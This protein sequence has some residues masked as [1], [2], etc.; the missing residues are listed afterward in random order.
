MKQI[1]DG[2]NI[3]K[4]IRRLWFPPYD[5]AYVEIN[6]QKYTL[7]NRQLLEEIAPKGS[8]QSFC[9]K[10]KMLNTSL[11]PMAKLYPRRS[12][13]RFQSPA[14]QQSQLLDRYGMSRI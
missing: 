1:L 9:R 6:G 13:C 10:N 12:R 11:S 4:K 14:V 8:T 2:D 3:E 7:I 5:G